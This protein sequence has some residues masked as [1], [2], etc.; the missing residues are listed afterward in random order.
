MCFSDFSCSFYGLEVFTTDKVFVDDPSVWFF[1]FFVVIRLGLWV[2]GRKNIGIKYH[3]HYVISGVHTIHISYHR[4]CWP[5]SPCWGTKF[6]AILKEPNSGTMS[7]INNI[8]K[9]LCAALKEWGAM[10]LPPWGWIS[11]IVTVIYVGYLSIL[12]HLFIHPIIHYYQHALC[13]F[14]L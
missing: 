9:Q 4:W 3:S 1:F 5:W 2:W 8:L 11:A 12:P 6:I 14:S 13:I 10:L 7:Y